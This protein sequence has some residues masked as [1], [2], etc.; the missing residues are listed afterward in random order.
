[1]M[2]NEGAMGPK[3][4]PFKAAFWKQF[5]GGPTP[6]LLKQMDPEGKKTFGRGTKG[7]GKGKGKKGAKPLP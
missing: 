1:M 6:E 4:N 2:V 5:G 7:K 3:I